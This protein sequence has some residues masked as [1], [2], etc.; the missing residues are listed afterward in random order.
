MRHSSN[1]GCED[2]A[3]DALYKTIDWQKTPLSDAAKWNKARPNIAYII[4]LRED[5][6]INNTDKFEDYNRDKD[7]LF[8]SK[9]T[10]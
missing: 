4:L 5:S 6:L 9:A 3:V 10:I 8:I 2:L 7:R 1:K